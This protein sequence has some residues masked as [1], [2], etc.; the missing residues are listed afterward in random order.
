MLVLGI[1]TSGKIGSTALYDKNK[2]TICE[3]NLKVKMN[4]SDTLM[5]AIDDIFKYSGYSMS[6]VS[7]IAVSMGPGSFTGIRVGMA[8][9]KGLAIARNISIVGVNTLDALAYGV[10]NTENKIMSI[11]DARKGRVYWALYSYNE[12]LEIKTETEYLDDDLESI[13]EKYKDE[14]IV[15]TGDGVIEY[16]NKIIEIMGQNAFFNNKSCLTSRASLVAEAAL[17]K[18]IDNVYSLEPF[19]ISKTQAERAREKNLTLQ[20]S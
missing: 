16:K 3:V 13:L 17:G 10:C 4:H 5:S 12:N 15:F 19:Y 1:D 9:A 11:I 20:L 18:K 8:A 14:K 2:G 7:L 6:D